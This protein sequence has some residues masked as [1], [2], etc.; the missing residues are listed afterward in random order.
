LSF[1]S[2]ITLVCDGAD[3]GARYHAGNASGSLPIRRDLES[4]RQE[5]ARERGW[6]MLR[7]AGR[8]SYGDYC[9][10]CVNRIE[11]ERPERARF[12]SRSIVARVKKGGAS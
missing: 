5:A 2:A 8:L 10:R 12:S 3:C 7:P 9:E 1:E 6:R 11:A 4:A